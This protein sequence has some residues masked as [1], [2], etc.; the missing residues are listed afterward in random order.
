M[1]KPRN[2]LLKWIVIVLGLCLGLWLVQVAIVVAT[3]KRAGL[4][5][6]EQ[7]EK[8]KVSRDNNLA[9]IHKAMV[10]AAD[11]DGGFPKAESWMD[12]ALLRLK[13]SDLSEEEAKDKLRIPGQPAGGYGYA[14]NSALSGRHPD[15]FRAKANTILV[16]ESKATTWNAAGD[17]AK[18]AAP[19]GKA[20]TLEG[21]VI[22]AN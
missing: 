2:P 22:P 21:K 13:T 20:V 1:A 12:T 3:A 9:A 10:Q 4:L 19:G 16:F 7:I 17:P 11:S 6:E 14:F 5:D 18:D 8:Y 15:D